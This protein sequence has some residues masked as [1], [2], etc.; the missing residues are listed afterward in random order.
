MNV[1][2]LCGGGGAEHEISLQSAQYLATQLSQ[3]PLVQFWQV[4]ITEQ[5]WLHQQAPCQLTPERQF[6]LPGLPPVSI[7]Y[8]IPCIHGYPGET[9]DIQSLLEQYRL[10]YLG[11]TPEAHRLC[12]NK[13]STKLWANQVGIPTL[14][15]VLLQKNDPDYIASAEAF[16]T[17]HPRV[18]VKPVAQGSSRG[19]AAASS[20]DELHLAL[21]Q[22]FEFDHQVMIEPH[23]QPR[24][25][26]VVVYQYDDQWVITEPGE[27]CVPSDRSYSYEEKYS[28]DSQTEVH[29]TAPDLS[30]AQQAQIQRYSQQLIQLFPLKDLARIDFFLDEQQQL[31]LNEINTFP[32]MTAIS[33]FPKLLNAQGHS[34]RHFLAQ[35]LPR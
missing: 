5:G 25:L 14:P 1:L 11:C 4:E 7:D 15:F 12:F 21:Q 31:Y 35:K 28:A 18:F 22:A 16:L 8:V 10:P 24:E 27:I 20:L 13:I 9:G 26:E 32:G 30:A 34:M 29:L 2:L 6:Q 23:V 17:S 33:M 3:L 19:C